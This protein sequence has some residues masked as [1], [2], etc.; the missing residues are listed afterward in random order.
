MPWGMLPRDVL[1]VAGEPDRRSARAARPQMTVI[2]AA[3]SRMAHRGPGMP[4]RPS[5]LGRISDAGPST[6]RE[7]GRFTFLAGVTM[8]PKEL[9]LAGPDI[10]D[11][12]PEP[13]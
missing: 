12:R 3:A 9:G 8:P 7:R 11:T 5:M 10:I 13:I 4:P 1:A 6:R 2:I